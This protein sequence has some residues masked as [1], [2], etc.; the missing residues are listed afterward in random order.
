MAEQ[1]VE[2]CENGLTVTAEFV[3]DDGL[4]V[5]WSQSGRSQEPIAILLDNGRQ[6]LQPSSVEKRLMMHMP[7]RVVA[8]LMARLVEEYP[9][10]F[11]PEAPD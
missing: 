10:A 7:A 8:R 6:K 9:D 11:E 4:G 2:V 3:S 5:T 1:P